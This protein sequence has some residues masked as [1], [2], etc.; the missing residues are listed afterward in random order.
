MWRRMGVQKM[1]IDIPQNSMEWFSLRAG[2]TTGSSI[3]K[4]MANYGR[5]F[6]QPARDHALNCACERITGNSIQ[7]LFT[8]AYMERGH[9]MEPLA[10]DLYMEQT[11]I[12]VGPGGFFDNGWT[13]CSP[14]GIAEKHGIIEVKTAIPSVHYKRIKKDSY[15]GA[16]RWQLIFNLKESGADWVDY[17]SYCPE[18][19]IKKRL[20]I[21]RIRR[22]QVADAMRQI[23]LRLEQF[24]KIVKQIGLEIT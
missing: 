12:G 14:D 5:A 23:D 7:T 9:E 11:G 24:E 1:W 10:K 22:P 21:K 3:A 4:V 16:H 17:I 6:G 13:G 19:P 15:D 20:Y 2:K 18:F 8:N